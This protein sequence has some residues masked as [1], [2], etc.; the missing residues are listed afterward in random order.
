MPPALPT[1]GGPN[2]LEI[3]MHKEI[4]QKILKAVRHGR[5]RDEFEAHNNM[6]F[7]MVLLKSIR[8]E[9][10]TAEIG[11]TLPIVAWQANHFINDNT[12]ILKSEWEAS[13]NEDK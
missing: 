11:E 10:R 7:D 3:P 12:A 8:F 1:K 6:T 4:K 5:Y 9:G 2:Y 13:S